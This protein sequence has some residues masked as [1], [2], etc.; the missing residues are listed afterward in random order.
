MF[1][2]KGGLLR[3]LQYIL[4]A[5]LDTAGLTQTL[6]ITASLI[7]TP[8]AIFTVSLSIPNYMHL[9]TASYLQ[10][11][12]PSNEHDYDNILFVFIYNTY[13]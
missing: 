5:G 11:V 10:G 3:K 9:P 2:L 7:H 13:L 6:T 1:K 8:H 4:C 12:A